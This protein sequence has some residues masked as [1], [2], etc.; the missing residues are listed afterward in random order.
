MPDVLRDERS[1]GYASYHPCVALS[2]WRLTILGR[3][4][5]SRR[6]RYEW[7]YISPDCIFGVAAAR[8]TANRSILQVE[9][10]VGSK[11]AR[12]QLKKYA[13]KASLLDHFNCLV[14][15]LECFVSNRF[16]E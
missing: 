3:A 16:S 4:R 14:F 2:G 15:P 9:V 8:W 7:S 11:T 12:R 1:V 13:E 10:A 5:I 6:A